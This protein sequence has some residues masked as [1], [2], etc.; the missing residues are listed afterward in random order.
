MT[1]EEQEA[2][3]L[4]VFNIECLNR[5]IFNNEC[6]TADMGRLCARV[7]DPRFARNQET[8]E[9]MC[10]FVLAPFVSSQHCDLLKAE[11]NSF[12]SSLASLALKKRVV[13]KYE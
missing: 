7:G 9:K 13:H 10:K 2:V 12:R 4:Y 6:R 11:E 1:R 8:D 3:Q 5:I